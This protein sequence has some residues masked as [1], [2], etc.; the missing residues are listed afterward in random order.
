VMAMPTAGTNSLPAAAMSDSTATCAD[1]TENAITM[2]G[3][4][5]MYNIPSSAEGD[6]L[7]TLT[8]QVTQPGDS[9]ATI[10]WQAAYDTGNAPA[11]NTPQTGYAV[12]DTYIVE[13]QSGTNAGV[14]TQSETFVIQDVQRVAG[15]TFW[16]DIQA[17][18]PGN[19]YTWTF[20]NPSIAVAYFPA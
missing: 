7:V 1:S 4:G 11:C 13:E 3:F 5:M 14:F 17:Y 9:G 16:M 8:F 18:Q 20:A 10:Q 6:M 2:A 12:G 15:T 19:A